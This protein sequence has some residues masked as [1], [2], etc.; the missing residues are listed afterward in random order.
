MLVSLYQLADRSGLG[1]SRGGRYE[2]GAE[3]AGLI[4]DVKINVVGP[5]GRSEVVGGIVSDKG[6]GQSGRLQDR[7]GEVVPVE[8]C[9]FG[10]L[11]VVEDPVHSGRLSIESHED[12]DHPVIGEAELP[13][14]DLLRRLPE[15]HPLIGESL[16]LHQPLGCVIDYREL[17]PE[18]EE[19][20]LHLLRLAP[21][22]R[23]QLRQLRVLLVYQLADA[24][25]LPL[26]EEGGEIL[27]E[28]FM[29]EYVL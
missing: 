13:T 21:V 7:V 6:A 2:C 20:F 9:L 15:H 26:G 22:H 29:I 27:G 11:E 5:F 17:Y 1:D 25:P 18:V 8:D 23:R 19:P 4:R 28:L 14:L 24:L 10:L 16:L 12:S 3:V